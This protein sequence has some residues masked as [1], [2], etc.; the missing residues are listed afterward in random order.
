M[1]AID[2]FFWIFGLISCGSALVVAFSPR[3]IHS[4]FALFFC[5]FGVAGLYAILGA[6]FLAAVQVI[7]YIGGILVLLIFGVFLTN[8]LSEKHLPNPFTHWKSAAILSVLMLALVLTFPAPWRM[9]VAGSKS[10]DQVAGSS[11]REGVEAQ[12]P[13]VSGRTPLGAVPVHVFNTTTP[14]GVHLLTTYVI[15]FEL[16]SILLL[17]AMIG[18]ASIARKEVH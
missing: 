4:V 1:E 5:F 9:T 6:D 15:A 16:A 11:P 13:T 17:V 18:A 14:I 7:L 8:R 3:L 10:N 2:V 12:S